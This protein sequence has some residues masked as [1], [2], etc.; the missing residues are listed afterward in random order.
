[1]STDFDIIAAF[2]ALLET[3]VRYIG[4]QVVDTNIDICVCCVSRIVINA[5]SKKGKKT[6]IHCR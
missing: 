6:Y 2:N 4:C 3:T 5:P 1:M